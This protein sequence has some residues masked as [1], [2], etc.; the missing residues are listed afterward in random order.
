[1]YSKTARS[2]RGASATRPG[3][4]FAR[5]LPRQRAVNGGTCKNSDLFGV[6]LD[7]LLGGASAPL[8]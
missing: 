8:T 5:I 7:R 4:P 6:A 1:M 3:R 2:R